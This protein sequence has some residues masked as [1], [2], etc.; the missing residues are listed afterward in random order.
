MS[1][2]ANNFDPLAYTAQDFANELDVSRETYEAFAAWEALLVKWN[3]TIN[4]VSPSALSG[5][6][7]RHALD[8]WQV[9]ALLPSAEDAP[10][11][12][13][14]DLGSGAGFPGLAV[15]I[16]CK[17]RGAGQVTLV[18]SAGK[19]ANFLRTVIRELDLPATVWADRAEKLTPKPYDIITARAFARMPRLLTYAQPFWGKGTKAVLLKGQNMQAELTEAQKCW[20]F[21]HDNRQSRSDPQGAVVVI[22]GLKATRPAR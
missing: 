19:K 11:V 2:A 15:A 4:L 1:E 5:F 3:R 8:S 13:C 7:L 14:L 18:E 16:A 22:T 21:E 20:S 10:N 6:W 17:A 12:S 9:A